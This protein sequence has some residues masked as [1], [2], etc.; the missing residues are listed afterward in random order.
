MQFAEMPRAPGGE[1]WAGHN[2]DFRNDRLGSL[3]RLAR[4][5]Q[6]ILRLQ[7][8]VPGVHAAVVNDPDLVHEMHVEKARSFLKSD[9]MRFALYPL[10]GEGL[11]T[12]N[13][14]LWQRQ[15]KL[16]APLFVPRAIE[17]YAEDMV[18]CARRTVDAWRDDQR[19]ELLTETT[20]L[21]MS[22]A[23]KT[24]FDADTFDEADEL[25]HAL[26]VAL[27]WSG[28]IVG[29]PFSVLHMVLKR[30]LERA[31]LTAPGWLAPELARAAEAFQGP[32]FLPGRRGAELR[33]AI[34]LLDERVQRMI[35]EARQSAGE[36]SDLLARLLSVRDESGAPMSDRQVR[37]EVLT[38]FVAGHETTATGLAW[39][40]YLAAR[41]PEIYAALEREVDSLS[42]DPTVADL[43][44]LGLAARVFK[45][46]LRLYPPV[47]IFGRDSHGEV[48]LGGYELPSPT[49]I[50]TS[51]LA[52]HRNGAL[53]PEPERFDPERF[54]PEAEASRHRYAYLPFGAGPRICIG[55]HFAI[56]EA[57][58]ALAVILRRFRVES[59]ADDVP[60][61]GATLR[62]ER[63]V[64]VRV[65][66]RR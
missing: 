13:G 30:R 7:L 29:R 16:M 17:S 40:L 58:L 46:A 31:S 38:L 47:Y 43:P 27:E 10:A 51:P 45:E 8:P 3:L 35:D 52:L 21:T 66:K 18:T 44:R 11:F 5:G 39:S 56:M 9:M 49:N 61:P 28:W 54:Q 34:A 65:T 41:H 53:F 19:F 12:A 2:A 26:T 33:R 48:S 24:L 32:I 64:R 36:R 15:R 23:G 22:V 25:G 1:G 42:D 6:P 50:L 55:N 60:H 59:V 62:P 4:T 20:R 37:D 57:Q 14:E 63:G